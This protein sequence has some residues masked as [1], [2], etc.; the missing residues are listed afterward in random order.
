MLTS[1]SS[2]LNVLNIVAPCKE[3]IPGM[4]VFIGFVYSRTVVEQNWLPYLGRRLEL[5]N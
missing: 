5:C 4:W 1:T 2:L 3:R